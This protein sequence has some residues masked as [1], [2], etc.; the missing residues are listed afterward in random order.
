M[1]SAVDNLDA[2]EPNIFPLI[3]IAPGIRTNNP[4]KVSR[5]IF[6]LPR[7]TPAI[8]SPQAQINKAIKLSFKISS[9]SSKKDEKVWRILFCF[10]NITTSHLNHLFNLRLLLI[11]QEYLQENT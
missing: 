7:I 3:P 2:N 1:C 4:G 5:K 9:C 10:I 8:K 6:I 11:H